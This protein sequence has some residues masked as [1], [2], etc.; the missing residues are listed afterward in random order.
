MKTYVLNF[1]L[2]SLLACTTNKE[3]EKILVDESKHVGLEILD[4]SKGLKVLFSKGY[5]GEARKQ[6]ELISE[7]YTF[8]SEIM[9]DKKEFSLLVIGQEDWE[10]NAYG[11]MPGFPEY[12]KGNLIVGAGQNVLADNYAQMLA[13]FPEEM[14]TSLY[15]VYADSKGLLDMKLYFDKQSLHELTHNFQDPKNQESFSV[16]RWLEEI[17]A[18][19]G[20]YA[21]YKFKRPAELPY[22]MS[23]V[24]FSLKNPP[25]DLAYHSLA[26]FDQHYYEME[27]PNYGQYQMR[28]TQTAKELIDKLGKDILKPLNEF[29]IRYDESWKGKWTEEELAQKLGEEVHPELARVIETW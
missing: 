19:M 29:L 17:H 22:V 4:N 9:G 24:D 23:L 15:E 14:T 21:F 2:I 20:L 28:F 16:S 13:S 7:A 10:R 18:N 1:F 3:E 11:P 5:E 6:S 27:T 8:L 25:P 26:D 12:Y